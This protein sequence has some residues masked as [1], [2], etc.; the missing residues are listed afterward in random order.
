MNTLLALLILEFGNE[1]ERITADYKE[2]NTDKAEW[3]A[4]FLALLTRYLLLAYMLG[5]DTTTLTAEQE[6][7]VSDAVAN[8]A[9]Y[10]DGFKDDIGNLTLEEATTRA[11][12][13][14]SSA[15]AVYWDAATGELKLPAYPGDGSTQCLQFCKCAWHIVWLNRAKGH[16]NAYWTLGEA[17]HCP[18]CE[19][20]TRVWNPLKIRNWQYQ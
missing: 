8:Q 15:T 9:L 6:Q 1:L 19:E 5:L 20:R 13:Y 3:R 14:A 2:G 10:L 17:E 11:R 16:A 7:A 4:K 18:D 12:L